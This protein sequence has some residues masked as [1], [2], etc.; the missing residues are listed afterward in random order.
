[1]WLHLAAHAVAWV[2]LAD[3]TSIPISGATSDAQTSLHVAEV[4]VIG[5]GLFAVIA[6]LINRGRRDGG[7][8]KQESTTDSGV[9]DTIN[10]ILA[11]LRDLEQWRLSMAERNRRRTKEDS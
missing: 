11:R 7:R 10:D 2:H 4:T 6:A 1:M 8:W 3:S 9:H 5:G